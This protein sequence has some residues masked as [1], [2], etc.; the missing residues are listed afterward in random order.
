MNKELDLMKR[1]S[2]LLLV[3]LAAVHGFSDAADGKPSTGR[4]RRQV[5]SLIYGLSQDD[6]RA[7]LG[8]HNEGRGTVNPP[9]TDMTLMVKT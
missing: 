4:T 1:I 6:I 3:Y 7:I 8:A 2:L 5:P 9:A